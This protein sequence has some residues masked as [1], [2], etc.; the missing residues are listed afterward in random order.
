MENRANLTT[1]TPTG[2]QEL[3]L[4]LGQLIRTRWSI[5]NFDFLVRDEVFGE[6]RSRV[7]GQAAFALATLRGLALNYLRRWQVPNLTAA[8]QRFAA[9]PLEL[10]ARL[11]ML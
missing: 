11:E 7:Q 9:K 3:A 10:L 2:L 6:D 5:E 4:R 8:I 1:D